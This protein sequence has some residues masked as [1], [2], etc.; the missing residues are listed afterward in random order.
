[1]R[2]GGGY[3]RIPDPKP[4]HCDLASIGQDTRA[5]Q[6]ADGSGF[7]NHVHGVARKDEMIG[8]EITG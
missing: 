3:Q 5:S 6:I 1:M 4:L 2:A 8:G 7:Q